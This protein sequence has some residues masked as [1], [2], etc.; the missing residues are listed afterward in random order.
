MPITHKK[1]REEEEEEE[2]KK[3]RKDSSGPIPC[4]QHEVKV[5]CN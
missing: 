4:T 5:R 2:K 1:N 3:K